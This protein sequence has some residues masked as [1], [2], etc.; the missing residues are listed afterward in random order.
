[1]EQ[2]PKWC[3]KKCGEEIGYVGHVLEFFAYPLLWACRS[4]FHYCPGLF[5]ASEEIAKSQS[6]KR[7]DHFPILNRLNGTRGK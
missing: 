2:Y 3:C 5:V 1:M 4:I 6:N 7:A